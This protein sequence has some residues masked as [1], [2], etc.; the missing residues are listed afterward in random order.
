MKKC[1]ISSVSALALA[2]GISSANAEEHAVAADWTGFYV[3][4]TLGGVAGEALISFSSD[5]DLARGRSVLGGVNVGFNMQRDQLVFGIEGDYSGLNMLLCSDGCIDG[6]GHELTTASI[7]TLRARAGMLVNDDLL[8]YATAGVGQLSGVY[9]SSDIL[10]V[11]PFSV[12]RS[13]VGVGAELKVT[14]A[15]SLKLEALSFFGPNVVTY[16]D[17]SE[18]SE[19]RNWAAVRVGFNFGF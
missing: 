17:I 7:M 9:S 18:A 16:G 6:G 3:G 12:M 19:L 4:V 11:G 14:E 13:V 15:M 10:Y 1:L 2:V 8:V 5:D